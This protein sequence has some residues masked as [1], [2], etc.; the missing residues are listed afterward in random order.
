[1][2]TYSREIGCIDIIHLHFFL[3]SADIIFDLFFSFEEK[4][5]SNTTA[6]TTIDKDVPL[7]PK[8]KEKKDEIK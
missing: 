6:T 5:T 7:L 8:K 3:F 2:Y 4:K 1:M